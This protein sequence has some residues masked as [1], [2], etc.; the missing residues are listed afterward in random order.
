[1]DKENLHH[2]AAAKGHNKHEKP[3]GN[4]VHGPHKVTEGDSQT[5]LGE[6]AVG[7][8]EP[9]AGMAMELV[10]ATRGLKGDQSVGGGGGQVESL[11]VDLDGRGLGK[12]I[13]DVKTR[14]AGRPGVAKNGLVVAVQVGHMRGVFE[15]RKLGSGLVEGLLDSSTSTFDHKLA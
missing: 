4:Q 13:K 12:H 6:L 7:G 1:M 2:G 15:E 10:L 5:I 3:V 11:A 9:S 14:R 8:V